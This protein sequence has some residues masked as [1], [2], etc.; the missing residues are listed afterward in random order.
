MC[1][2]EFLIGF[3]ISDGALG[4]LITILIFNAF[5]TDMNLGIITS[6]S[7]I[8]SMCSIKLYEKLFKDKPDKKIL[9]LS[10]IIPV[11]SVLLVL[12]NTN[13]ITIIIY[14]LC[15]EIFV[16]GI[17]SLNRSIRLFNIADSNIINKEDQSEFFSIRE[18]ILN[19]GRMISYSILLFAG[20]S[21]SVIALNI[22]LIILT[23]SITV[24]GFILKEIEKF[25]YGKENLTK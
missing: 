22:S 24:M 2:V 7:T 6:I 23:L 19:F 3:S 8:F 21:G 12:F 16:N 10:S 5:K 4:T 11:I 25:E 17:L 15:Y 14:S 9:I 13:N 1:I 18:G 20:M